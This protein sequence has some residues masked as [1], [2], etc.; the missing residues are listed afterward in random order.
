MKKSTRYLIVI[1][2][3]LSCG[4]FFLYRV[5]ARRA[6]IYEQEREARRKKMEEDRELMM[7]LVNLNH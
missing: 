4:F 3:G 1:L 2:T 7:N 6:K 5:E